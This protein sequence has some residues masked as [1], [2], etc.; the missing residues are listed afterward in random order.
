M[1][2]PLLQSAVEPPPLG[3]YLTYQ[4]PL[5][6]IAV[7]TGLDLGPLAAADR[8]PAPAPVPADELTAEAVGTRWVLLP[9]P[10]AIRL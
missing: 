5:P 2:D 4:V 6:D 8:M 7:L 10:S 3:A 1:L 9:E